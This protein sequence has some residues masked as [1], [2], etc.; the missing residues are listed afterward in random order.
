MGGK[1]NVDL[2]AILDLLYGKHGGPPEVDMV[3]PTTTPLS[4]GNGG[5]SYNPEDD[6]DDGDVSSDRRGVLRRGVNA[7]KNTVTGTVKGAVETASGAMSAVKGGVTTARENVKGSDC[8]VCVFRCL[9]FVYVFA[10]CS[11][12]G[13][14]SR[15][16]CWEF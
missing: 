11:W 4:L 8:F 15:T 2:T 13:R 1:Q 7:V 3:A 5:A 16:T 14:Y 6:D 12:L 9:F 10:F